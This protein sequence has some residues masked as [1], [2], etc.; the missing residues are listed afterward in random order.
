MVERPIKKSER[1]AQ[2]ETDAST[3]DAGSSRPSEGRGE[4]SGENRSE[5]RPAK[6][7]GK[8]K[9]GRRD[10]ERSAAPPVNPALLRGPRPVKA[11]PEPEPV[12]EEI[13]AETAAEA[14]EEIVSEEVVAEEV[15]AEEAASVEAAEAAVEATVDA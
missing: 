6:G 2:A 10:E 9:G 15:V 12:I 14:T 1:L 8:G 3:T 7:K 13:P 4:R 5:K 11:K